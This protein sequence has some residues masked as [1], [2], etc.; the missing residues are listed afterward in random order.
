M[1]TPTHNAHEPE[2]AVEFEAAQAQFADLPGEHGILQRQKHYARFFLRFGKGVQIEAG[3]HFAHPERIVLDDDA[4][5]NIGAMIYGS[6]GVWIGRHARIGP[7]CFIHSANHD[8]SDSERAYFER[9]YIEAGVQIGDLCLV[10]ANV[11]ILPGAE[12]GAGCFVACGAVVTK[13]QYAEGSRLMGLPAKALQETMVS[14]APPAPEIVILTP[15]DRQCEELARH[16]LIPLGLPQV[17][18][19][20]ETEAVPESA[21]SVLLLGPPEWSPRIRGPQTIWR[22]SAGTVPQIAPDL[23]ECRP[24]PVV[25]QAD[26]GTN[27]MDAVPGWSA[28]WILNR[29]RKRATPMKGRDFREWVTTLAILQQAFEGETSLHKTILAYLFRERPTGLHG[30]LERLTDESVDDWCRRLA[31]MADRA[32]RSFLKNILRR[33]LPAPLSYTEAMADPERLVRAV[34]EGRVSRDLVS[35]FAKR[36][37][38][39][40]ANGLRLCAFSLAALLAGDED[41]ARELLQAIRSGEWLL[42][43]TFLFRSSRGRNTPCLSPMTMALWALAGRKGLAPELTPECFGAGTDTGFAMRW[44]GFGPGQFIDPERR[45]VASSLVENW[46]LL[47]SA[48]CPQGAQFQLDNPTYS[49]TTLGLEHRWFEVFRTIQGNQP[50]IRLRPWPAGYRAAVSIRYDVDRPITAQRIS[51]HVNLQA[52]L[53]NGPCAA[54]Y[55]FSD[56]PAFDRQSSQMSRHWQERG[57]HVETYAD[58]KEDLGVTHHSS[59]Q[60]RYW[61]GDCSTRELA[62]RGAKYGEFLATRLPTP[63]P[64]LLGGDEGSK[65]EFWVMPLHFPLEGSTDGSDLSYFDERRA[66]FLEI[67]AA[68]GLAIVASHPDIA[69]Q[70]LSSLLQR[71]FRTDHYWFATPAHALERVRNVMIPGEVIAFRY[72]NGWSLLS[73]KHLADVAVEIW[74]PGQDNPD[75]LT[76]QL[77]QGRPR[78]L[79]CSASESF[80]GPDADHH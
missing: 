46:K 53:A 14:A 17:A 12:I 24:F 39:K 48:P 6:G 35:Q 10:S 65:P 15:T 47:H 31:S 22:L 50:L 30:R 42:P 58:T 79:A 54:W 36:M 40:G 43:G 37:W 66:Y 8:I 55:Y 80:L 52:S 59:R 61:Q 27:S 77:I 74:N 73:R 21:H 4:R 1:T 38:P 72:G 56:D 68:G 70:L 13:G 16:I 28:F 34:L 33:I 76:T 57:L 25:R 3:C 64:A 49:V 19:M 62:L 29:L 7:R 20:N 45:L 32:E 63:R 5:I 69:P 2:S 78:R 71:E 11:S 9:G 18:V 26:D 67:L 23:P 41:C 60:S 75:C 44:S 51:E